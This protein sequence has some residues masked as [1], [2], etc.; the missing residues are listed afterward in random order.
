METENKTSP[1]TCREYREE[2]ILLALQ[3]KLAAPDLT[4]EEKAYL[5]AEI[6]RVESR[7]GMD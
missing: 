6:A 3:K 2:M 5:L 7:M 4:L 1:Y